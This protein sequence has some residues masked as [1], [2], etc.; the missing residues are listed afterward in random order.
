LGPLV[1]AAS[2]GF[3]LVCLIQDHRE[4]PYLSKTLWLP[5]IWLFVCSSKP[6]TMWMNPAQIHARRTETTL[7]EGNSIE[8]VFLILLIAVGLSLLF[9]RAHRFSLPFK[10]NAALIVLIVYI[11]LSVLWAGYADI[12]LK[13]W[14]RLFGDIIMVL[15]ILTEDHRDEAIE[16]LLRRCAIVLIP[17]SIVFIRYYGNIGIGYSISGGRMWTGVTTNKNELG[18]LCA[19]MGIFFI[20]RIIKA[21]PRFKGLDVLFLIQIL[22]LLR[23]ARSMTS[24]TVFVMG[25]VMLLLFMRLK[26][27]AKR[28][29]KLARTSVIT[30][31]TLQGLAV[32]VLEQSLPALFFS[33]IGRNA[34]FT[35]RAPLWEGLVEIGTQRPFLGS[36]F[37]NFWVIN[38]KEIWN[39][40]AFHPVQGHNGYLDIFLDLGLVGLGLLIWLI[41]STYRKILRDHARHYQMA[42]LML[43]FFIMVLVHNFTEASLV[44]PT[45][46]LWALFLLATVSVKSKQEDAAAVIGPDAL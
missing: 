12:V 10:E 16:H 37:G 42:T 23:G 14:L 25:V 24:V 1:L 44:K 46:L 11:L 22:Y 38:L 35:G 20:W 29:T 18:F 40:F 17:L 39:K 21:R 6:I 33:L 2:L 7:V 32:G 4:A 28:I 31:M 15:V 27:D 45:N 36:G 8:R 34:S 43:V 19:Y 9:K 26:G 13:R 41:V 30:V 3:I 5:Y